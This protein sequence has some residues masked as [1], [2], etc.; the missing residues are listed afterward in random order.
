MAIDTTE[1]T[2]LS[3]SPVIEVTPEAHTKILEIRGGEDDPETLGLRIEIIGAAGVD[4]QY[5]LSFH[6]V[7]ESESDD[8]VVEQDGLP[9]II[10]A[11]SVENITGATLD[12]PSSGA[13]AGGLVLRNPN[14][15]DPL[16][17]IDVELEGDIPEKI[18]TLLESHI[19]PSLAAHG[20]FATLV[21]VDDDNK[22]FITMGGGCQ[23]CSMSRMTLTEGIQATIMA[24]IPEVTEV[25][26]A[27]DHTA[28][29]SPFYS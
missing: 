11:N 17:G 18:H 28:G 23:G 14:R 20:G 7:A 1:A 21:G 2:E 12:L 26:D 13:N 19:N 16:A 15:P 25:V 6:E 5:D 10:P 3:A 29:D 24:A 4:Y 9:V 22:V 27:T 8:I